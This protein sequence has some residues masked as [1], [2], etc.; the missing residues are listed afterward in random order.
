M[1]GFIKVIVELRVNDIKLGNRKLFTLEYNATF[2]VMNKIIIVV[3]FIRE[4]T[5]IIE[6]VL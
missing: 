4:P 2:D 6:D 1:Q 3:C 5:I